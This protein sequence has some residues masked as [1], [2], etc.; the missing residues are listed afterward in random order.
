MVFY[1]FLNIAVFIANLIPSPAS[2]IPAP[3]SCTNKGAF[4]A[5][6][7]SESTW[8]TGI[9]TPASAV[10]RRMPVETYQTSV[11]LLWIFHAVKDEGV[12]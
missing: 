2:A 12:V 6:I 7:W 10:S 4:G 3:H 8:V 1:Y 11:M 5:R 9:F